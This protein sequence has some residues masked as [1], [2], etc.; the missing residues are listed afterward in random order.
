ME[1]EQ[2]R[3]KRLIAHEMSKGELFHPGTSQ[4]FT[5]ESVHDVSSEGMGLKVGGYLRQG[6]QVRL[7]FKRGRVHVQMSGYVVWCTPESET[8][9][10]KGP[11]LFMMGVHL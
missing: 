8:R 5:V 10:E 6:E 2:R 4:Y 1:V 9:S 7:G 11:A 3:E